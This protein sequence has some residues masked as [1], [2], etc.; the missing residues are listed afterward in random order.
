MASL[1]YRAG[2]ADFKKSQPEASTA[3]IP[4]RMA[5][6]QFRLANL[7]LRKCTGHED[8]SILPRGTAWPHQEDYILAALQAGFHLGKIVFVIYWLF[9]DFENHVATA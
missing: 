1:N 5:P 4:Y 8:G 6:C 9:V 2:Y 3:I 7:R